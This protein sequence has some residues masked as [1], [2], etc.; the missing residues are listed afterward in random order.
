MLEFVGAGMYRITE[1]ICDKEL[2]EYSVTTKEGV[3]K[4]KVNNGF[5]KIKEVIDL[6]AYSFD[7]GLKIIIEKTEEE[8]KYYFESDMIID[9]DIFPSGLK[10]KNEYCKPPYDFEHIE[11]LKGT[12]ALENIDGLEQSIIEDI[13]DATKHTDFRIEMEFKKATDTEVKNVLESL[14][15][16]IQHFQKEALININKGDNIVKKGVKV[17][18]GG[19]AVA[20][21]ISDVFL[22]NK[23]KNIENAY[24]ILSHAT[25]IFKTP[26]IRI[27]S[28]R[29]IVSKMISSMISNYSKKSSI[30]SVY[31]V[32]TEEEYDRL[33]V[34][35]GAENKNNNDFDVIDLVPS[36]YIASI[37]SLPTRSI[38]GIQIKKYVEFGS[39]DVHSDNS[40]VILGNL[41]KKDKMNTK[42]HIDTM[43]L[44]KHAL[45]AGVTGSGKTTTIKSVLLQLHKK[46]I[47][48]LIFEPAKTEYRSLKNEIPGLKVYRLGVNDAENFQINAFEF[49]EGMNLQTHLDYLK[50]VFIAA[51]PMYGPMPYIL[52]QGIY[53]IYEDYGWDFVSG[54]NIYQ[55]EISDRKKLFPIMSDLY[56]AIDQVTDAVGYSSDTQNDVKGALRVRIGSMI[57]GAK[58]KILNTQSSIS[59]KELITKSTVLELE[60]IGDNQE[61]VFLMGMILIKIYEYYI[62]Q[63]IFQKEIKNLL[64]IEEAHRLLE[65]VTANNNNEIAD[66]KGKAMELFNDVLSEVR[67]YGQGIMVAEQIPTK[68][69]VDVIKNTNLK[70][71]HRLYAEDDRDITGKSIGLIDEQIEKIVKLKTGEAITF[72]DR[73]PEPV[74]INVPLNESVLASNDQGKLFFKEKKFDIYEYLL[75][76]KK[77]LLFTNKIL[78][79][80]LIRLSKQ[81]FISSLTLFITSEFKNIKTNEIDFVALARKTLL[82]YIN[83]EGKQMFFEDLIERTEVENGLGIGGIDWFIEWYKKKVAIYIRDVDDFSE[84]SAEVRLLESGGFFSIR[85]KITYQGGVTQTKR[86]PKD[87]LKKS[88]VMDKIDIAMFNAGEVDALCDAVMLVLLEDYENYFNEYFEVVPLEVNDIFSNVKHDNTNDVSSNNLLEKKDVTDIIRQLEN[89]FTTQQQLL[90][91]KPEESENNNMKHIELLDK[92]TILIRLLVIGQIGSLTVIVLLIILKLI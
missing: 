57:T 27:Y 86:N 71:I 37:V 70:I 78:G 76:N 19:E 38:K 72:H 16:K 79:S 49:E 12:I 3:N 75:A 15:K 48:F 8:L 47:P 89:I 10:I 92:N 36:E 31:E 83:N 66:L 5:V 85:R 26:I 63:G 21:S 58:G 81:E 65:N 2:M 91:M 80:F 9:A 17:V 34:E 1:F 43:D 18:L 28:E 68:I 56:H 54:E 62:S 88:G 14:N 20:Y 73:L 11:T 13:Y 39:N 29:E 82:R 55:D 84:F 41:V 33:N 90:A 52:E 87:I 50:S 51:F 23:I 44:T 7:Q 40:K 30:N 74:M 25:N 22:E 35:E 45:V 24:T 60:N 46:E 77:Y 69:S 59:I 4:L 61:K 53:K 32:L 67:T 42:I 6:I 64:V